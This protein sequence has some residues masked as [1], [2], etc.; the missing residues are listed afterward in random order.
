MDMPAPSDCNSQK[1]MAAM[2]GDTTD[3]QIHVLVCICINI[4]IYVVCV[5]QIFIYKVRDKDIVSVD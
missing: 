5:Y 4:Y 1:K 3:L 2:T